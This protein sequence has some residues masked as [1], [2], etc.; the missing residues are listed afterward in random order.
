MRVAIISFNACAGDAIGNLIAEK[1]A[2]FHERGADVR[3]FVE[4]SK[5][6]HPQV[7]RHCRVVA[8]PGTDGPEWEYLRAADLVIVE[9]GM[10]YRLLKW[11]PLL[12]RTGRRILFDYH[13][14]TPPGLWHGPQ[15]EA[16]EA[17]Q[18]QRGLVWFAGAALVHS[19]FAARE[20]QEPTR[21]PDE[22]VH[23]L[24]HQVDRDRFS[25][26]SPKCD[27]RDE[28][29]LAE[30]HL[31]LFVGRLAPNKGVPVLVEAL[32]HLADMASP[33][34]LL[35]VGDMSDVYQNEAEH[36]RR[37]AFELGVFDRVHFLGHVSDER[38]ADLYRSASVFVMPSRHE[39]FCI[40]VLE[41]MAAGLPVVAAR[42]GAL[43]ETVGPAGLTFTPDDSADLARQVRRILAPAPE[44]SKSQPTSRRLRI[45]VVSFRYGPAIV[46]GAEGSLRTMARVLHA[47]GHDVQVFT[48]CTLAESDWRNELA[49]G[50]THV[51]G[52]PV[53]RYAI[54]V[55]DRA[56][57]LDTVR[58]VLQAD[59]P[60]SLD[61]AEQYLE[62]SLHSTPLIDVLRSR[63]VEL[64]AIVT[65]PYLFGLT[66][67]VARAFPEKTILVPCFHDEPL[68]RLPVW[69]ECYRDVGAILY[70]SPEEQ[71]LAEIE[72]G[73]NHPGGKVQGAYM[74]DAEAADPVRGRKL[75]GEDARYVV[76]CGRYSEQKNLP[77]L[78]EYL[79]R[80]QVERPR[81]FSLICV[82]RGEVSLPR[83]DWIRDLGFVEENEKRDVLAG[84]DAL[85][86]LS[87]FESL[88]L[89]ALEAWAEGTPVIA[90]ARCAPL[91]GLIRRSQGGKAVTDYA[92]FAAALDD[93]WE[94]SDRWR[95][96]GQ[97]GRTY[98]R[99]H[100]GDAQ[101][102]LHVLE[103]AVRE[104]TIPLAE[105]MRR[106]GLIRAADLD[107]E[108]WRER[109]G[110]L[111]ERLLDQPQT[112]NRVSVAVRPRI[113]S[114]TVRA[115]SGAVLVPVTICNRGTQAVV[116]EG[117]GRMMIRA[118]I[119]D[120]SNT[121]PAIETALPGII[122]PGQEQSAAVRV[123]VPEL[124]GS[125]QVEL[126][127]VADPAWPDENRADPAFVRLDV[128][129]EGTRADSGCLAE[130]LAAV[131][132]ALR[133]AERRQKL[134]DEYL[135]V[136]QGLFARSKR[137]IKAKLLGNFKHAY[138]DVLSRQQSAFNRAVVTALQELSEGCSLLDHAQA[139]IVEL[140]RQSTDIARKQTELERQ[141]ASLQ[142]ALVADRAEV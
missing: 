140:Q 22:R 17:G 41:A 78:I 72:L 116:S 85:I 127:V 43:P 3:V 36:C 33:V 135:D 28:L 73:L 60:V 38:L 137:W 50:T 69:R 129:A 106:N 136:T 9:Y 138:V 112:P 142:S 93:L 91:A 77:L 139:P 11:L 51:D 24:P 2:F 58:R 18:R 105:K 53:H 117:E 21:Y 23:V 27:V 20:I 13:G 63:L 125:Y 108:R 7:E 141:I 102:F 56:R 87:R 118:V 52:I 80:Y 68:A 94:Q 100:F 46:G 59:E 44:S 49:T 96:I 101:K 26:G 76:Y 126:Q 71:N 62:H 113:E 65:G 115:G 119:V 133:D 70:H 19:R 67:D 103:E 10:A 74:Q 90:D 31:L 121:P 111:V 8:A 132:H 42:A 6:L 89:V 88:S 123:L 66:A 120:S 86:Q 57:H 4:N 5:R 12:A 81:R 110:F 37:R 64:D 82:G 14:V 40:P 79:E 75:A 39:G 97:E 99:R 16:L 55:H 29:G 25:P 45:A 61:L 15:R 107:R 124:A 30:A 83:A 131:D 98:V 109:F 48:T 128:E 47:A 54:D 34:H 92:S 35:I 114:R 95:R 104:L 1:L 130:V 32:K 122:V 134:P 84:A